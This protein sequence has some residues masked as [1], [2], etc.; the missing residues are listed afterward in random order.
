MP[1][2][3]RVQ[4]GAHV[5]ILPHR[6]VQVAARNRHSTRARELLAARLRLNERINLTYVVQHTILSKLT[7]VVR[8]YDP[9]GIRY[10][11]HHSDVMRV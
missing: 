7:G 8:I 5:Y 11:V 4:S 6:I 10:K 3:L 1:T 2:S 9:T